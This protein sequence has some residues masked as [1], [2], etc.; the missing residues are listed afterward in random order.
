LSSFHSFSKKV[1]VKGDRKDFYEA[2]LDF[3][4]IIKGALIDAAR[5][6]MK[7]AHDTLVG[8][9]NLIEDVSP[10]LNEEEKTGLKDYKKIYE[11]SATNFIYLDKNN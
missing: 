10:D 3:E 4:K 5:S 11:I 1:W 8:A 9:E 2:E 6:R 7:I